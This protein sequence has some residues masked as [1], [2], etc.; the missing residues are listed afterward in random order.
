[1]KKTLVILLAVALLAA[2]VALSLARFDVDKFRPAVVQKMEQQLGRPVRMG[3]ISLGWRRGIA[4]E[5]RDLAIYPGSQP[6]G[7]PA[8]HV[9]RVSA[10]L[11]IFPLFR[12]DLQLSALAFIG[13]RVH[14][15]RSPAGAIDVEG[16]TPL[17]AKVSPPGAPGKPA[18]PPP[19]AAPSFL[20]RLLELQDG[21]I[22]FTD[23][24]A[25][26]PL[27]V[28]IRDAYLIVTNLS[29][30]R[31]SDFECRFTL[32]S[33]QPNI[34][35]EGRV[36]PPAGGRPGL[37][38]RFRLEMDLAR[39][40]VEAI[41]RAFPALKEMGLENGIEGK[42][43]VNVDRLALDP[44][45]LDSLQAQIR[46][47][48]GRAQLA[49]MSAPVRDLEVE[50]VSRGGE[51]SL[52]ALSGKVGEGSFSAKGTVKGLP[53]Q[54][55]G[56][57]QAKAEGLSLEEL[58]PAKP[59][60]P[61]L[62]GRFSG[63]FGG[64]FQGKSWPEISRSL[65]GSGQIR[66]E[67]GVLSHMNLLRQVF[68]Q[69]TLIPGLTGTLLSR[70]PPSYQ[71]KLNAPDTRFEPIQ[72]SAS[73]KGGVVSISD[74]RV[75]TDSLTL[76]GSCQLSLE[77][78]LQFPGRVQIEPQLSAA[79][80]RSVEE[81]RFLSDEQGRLEIPVLVQGKLPKVSAAPDLNAVASRLFSSRGEELVGQ[82]LQKVFE[83]EEKK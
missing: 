83:K 70:L 5:L 16:V 55:A 77:G 24:S 8:V 13:P 18:A 54:P 33:G 76:A 37:L 52:N 31:P 62:R 46:L 34:R 41:V 74:L 69:L 22:R 25:Q 49:R 44:A 75:A 23:L 61:A 72:L 48:G 51:V 17:P 32:F 57:L 6:E 47:S 43:V 39:L 38:E 78:D 53:G 56:V 4:L 82:L 30:D 29:L 42:L 45:G 65:A 60:E 26:P 73:A 11:K 19:P 15:V 80:I 2:G 79:L 58:A 50:A 59:D 3:K 36:T 66:L 10:V 40:H 20:I 64:D 12:G 63:S 14:I 35:A 21:R 1:M 68:D 81:M 71:E 27:D 9:D 67:D 28:E 7:D